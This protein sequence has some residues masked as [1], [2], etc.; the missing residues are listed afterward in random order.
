MDWGRKWLVD[1]RAG[2]ARIVLFDRSDNRGAIDVKMD[3]SVLDGKS[4]LNMFVLY[5][6]SKL[7]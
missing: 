2:K 7:D 6:S 1:F 3:E 4:S 5:F